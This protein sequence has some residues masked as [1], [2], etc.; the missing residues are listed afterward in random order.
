MLDG[1]DKGTSGGMERL[2]TGRFKQGN[3]KH[4]IRIQICLLPLQRL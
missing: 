4:T 3:V 2:L 1:P